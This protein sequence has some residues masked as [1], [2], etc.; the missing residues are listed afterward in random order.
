MRYDESLQNK[1][2]VAGV[3]GYGR[4]RPIRA[5]LLFSAL[6]CLAAMLLA[7]SSAQAQI[8]SCAGQ[9][10]W[11]YGPIEWQYHANGPFRRCATLISYTNQGGGH[12]EQ[13][14]CELRNSPGQYSCGIQIGVG[15]PSPW[16]YYGGGSSGGG[17]GI[18]QGGGF[19]GPG[20]S[21]PGGIQAFCQNNPTHQICK[22]FSM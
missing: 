10:G 2:V 21:S 22:H 3:P 17:G 4:A 20:G 15:E 12:Y 18:G 11:A 9:P 16:G 6:L 19:G 8:P 7:T 14:V 1:R 5:G 13:N